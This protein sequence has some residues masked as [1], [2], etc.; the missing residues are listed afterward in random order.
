MITLPSWGRRRG[1]GRRGVREGRLG[2]GGSGLVQGWFGVSSGMAVRWS[3]GGV[4]E[5]GRAGIRLGKDGEPLGAVK[6]VARERPPLV[7]KLRK[8][9]RMVYSNI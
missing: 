5:E 7:V 9:N 8:K 1:G 4:G 2:E 6:V 3:G